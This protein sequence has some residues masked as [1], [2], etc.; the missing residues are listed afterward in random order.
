MVAYSLTILH[1]QYFQQLGFDK[2]WDSCE[3]DL[4]V[5]GKNLSAGSLL[6][7]LIIHRSRYKEGK[8]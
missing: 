6:G 3:A 8:S 7:L 1:E 4:E 5:F 2:N